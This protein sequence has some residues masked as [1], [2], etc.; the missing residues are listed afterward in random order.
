MRRNKSL[1]AVTLAGI[2]AVTAFPAFAAPTGPGATPEPDSYDAETR[3]RLD[4]NT[5]EYDEIANRV[6]EYNPDMSRAW[7]SYMD[8]K[9]DY[10]NI[11]TELESRYPGI[12]DTA[13]GYVTA[14]KL[15]GNDV[16]VKTG[17]GLDSAYKSTMQSMRDTVNSWDNN[18]SNTRQLK[19]A[20]KQI[21][22]GA[23]QA[24]IGY[25]TMRKNITTLEK[26]VELY[27]RQSAAVQRQVE[28]GLGTQKD[29]LSARSSLLSAQSQLSSLQS[30]MDSTRRTL[31]LLLGY[32][33]DSDP[34]I[35]P[36]P[37]FDMDR[38]AGMNLEQDTTKA[39][40]NN[41]TLID[42]RSSGGNQNTNAQTENRLKAIDEGDQKLT[43]E[44]NRL[45]QDVMDKKAAYDAAVTGFTAAQES[46][47]AAGRQF[48]EGL[49]SEV[50][51]IG[52]QL[53]YYKKL[54]EEESANLSLLQA[55]ETY[56]WAVDGQATVE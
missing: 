23:Q 6:H 53:A 10:K 55:M 35:A 47:D 17:Q 20:E 7:D 34:V 1:I 5:L 29:L 15:T 19:K 37:E 25:E 41:Y 39:I 52:Q 18:R 49:T 13:D 33:P 30:Q 12:K 56:D 21:T 9:E 4:D 26:M 40:G 8:S 44:M 2:M 36:V 14:G 51:Y 38:L 27:E 45:Y 48:Q 24:Y 42:Q 3:A 54:A 31:C 32:D 22:S 28:H 43:I 11:L 16:L 46:N 50:Q